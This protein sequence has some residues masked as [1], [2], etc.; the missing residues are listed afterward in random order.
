MNEYN[1][2]THKEWQE[3]AKVIYRYYIDFLAKNGRVPKMREIGKEFGFSRARAEHI[4][5]RMVRDGYLIKSIYN[6]PYIPRVFEK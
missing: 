3:K 2:N 4:L 1:I 5:K 6:K